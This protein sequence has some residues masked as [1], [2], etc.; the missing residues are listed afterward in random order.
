[1]T[2]HPGRHHLDADDDLTDQTVRS[3]SDPPAAG[4]EPRRRGIA[5]SFFGWL[6][7]TGMSLLLTAAAVAAGTAL[8]ITHEVTV[9]EAGTA[10]SRNPATIGLAGVSLVALILFVGYYC[11][12][13]VAGR[14]ARF[15]GTKQGLG[16][17][18]WAVAVAAIVA[19][20]AST[21]GAKYNVLNG[22]NSFPRLPLSS[23]SLTRG[24]I[25]ALV[26][27]AVIS[28]V[29]ALIGGKAGMRYHRRI[30]RE[31]GL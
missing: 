3:A 11:G 21:A 26:V 5:A 8:G 1:M 14:M 22:L 31:Q 24:G 10:L 18:L 27:A 29:G 25:I 17:W 16:V 6:T 13:Y 12:G 15:G 19:I 28:L 23:E 9:G 4:R 2:T 30:D 7:A 20:L